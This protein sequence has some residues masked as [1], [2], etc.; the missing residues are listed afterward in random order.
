M[1][2][3]LFRI[4]N[5]NSDQTDIIEQTNAKNFK[6]NLSSFLCYHFSIQNSERIAPTFA[7]SYFSSLCER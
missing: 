2:A 6:Y 3:V 1:Q 7:F 4:R 5:Q